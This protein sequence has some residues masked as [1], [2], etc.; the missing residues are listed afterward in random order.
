VAKWQSSTLGLDKI[1]IFLFNTGVH[2]FKE[3]KRPAPPIDALALSWPL[4]KCNVI[5][6][7]QTLCVA[8]VTAVE[9]STALL[10]P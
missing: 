2:L 4:F 7:N 6:F 8:Y 5:A 3:L 9:R 10:V 1:G